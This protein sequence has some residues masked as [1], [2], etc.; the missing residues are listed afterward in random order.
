MADVQCISR[1]PSF[2][3]D[4]SS[5]INNEREG[6][7][8]DYILNFQRVLQ[9]FKKQFKSL[10]MQKRLSVMPGRDSDQEIFYST[11]SW[12]LQMICP[13]VVLYFVTVFTSDVRY[14]GTDLK[15]DIFLAGTTGDSG[16]VELESTDKVPDPF[17]RGRFVQYNKGAV[18][19]NF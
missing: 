5:S 7:Q 8:S 6:K 15:V 9:L 2:F 3:S 19:L 10:L 1:C 16:E 14:A 18:E 4:L 17:E 11:N 13:T 12:L